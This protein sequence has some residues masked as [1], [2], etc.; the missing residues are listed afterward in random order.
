MRWV[1]WV[2]VLGWYCQSWEEQPWEG[3]GCSGDGHGSDGLDLV[4]TVA[5][6]N[7]ITAGP[8]EDSLLFPAFTPCWTGHRTMAS[9]IVLQLP[10]QRWWWAQIQREGRKRVNQPLPPPGSGGYLPW[11]HLPFCSSC[12]LP[13]ELHHSRSGIPPGKLLQFYWWH[14]FSLGIFFKFPVWYTRKKDAR[15]SHLH[16]SGDEQCATTHCGKGGR[17]RAGIS[18]PKGIDCHEE[19]VK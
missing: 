1:L 4:C 11:M 6:E 15:R 16:C 9:Q 13:W 7:C 17:D 8:T 2:Y 3:V 14:K 12:P 5:L 10:W 19:K 18:I